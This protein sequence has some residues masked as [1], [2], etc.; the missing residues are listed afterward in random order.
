L[1]SGYNPHDETVDFYQV[2]ATVAQQ[3]T[4]T[5]DITIDGETIHTTDEHP[6]LTAD[7]DWVTAESLSV[8]DEVIASDGTTGRISALERINEPQMM[9]NLSVAVVATYLV[10]EGRWVVHNVKKPLIVNIDNLRDAVR[11]FWYIEA[12][13]YSQT[14]NQISDLLD[15]WKRSNGE[16][17]LNPYN[18]SAVKIELVNEGIYDLGRSGEVARRFTGSTEYKRI[19]QGKDFNFDPRRG[20]AIPATTTTIRPNQRLQGRGG[21]R[22]AEYFYDFSLENK[23]IKRSAGNS[24]I[25]EV[26]ILDN[27][28]NQDIINKG[29]CFS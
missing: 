10:G 13:R 26:R 8:D 14:N 27:I 5:L 11:Y 17:G 23:I 12:L 7:G 28:V 1:I 25:P 15:L 22:L 24:Q 3:H 16:I 29:K 4:H 9:Y 20:R 18:S 21:I 6:F 19:R 2:T